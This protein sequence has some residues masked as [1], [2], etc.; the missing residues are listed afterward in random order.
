MEIK[1]DEFCTYRMLLLAK[2][3]AR[4]ACGISFEDDE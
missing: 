2:D 3:A 1:T 4:S